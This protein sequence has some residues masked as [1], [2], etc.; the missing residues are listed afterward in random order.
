MFGPL[1]NGVAE[2]IDI[3]LNMIQMLILASIIISWVG[4]DPSNQIVMMIRSSTEP[5]FKPIRKLTKNFPGPMDWSPMLLLLLIVFIQRGIVPYIR[6]M[7][8]P[9][10]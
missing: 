3:V 4:A 2:V 9:V 8:G 1:A 5:L 10:G 6:M 7:A